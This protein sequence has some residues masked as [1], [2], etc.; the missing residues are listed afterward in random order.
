M[1]GN[2]VSIWNKHETK[3]K[4]STWLDFMQ[5]KNEIVCVHQKKVVTAIPF[6]R[7]TNVIIKD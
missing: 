7:V 6:Q 1:I 3:I 2:R 4:K 5:L